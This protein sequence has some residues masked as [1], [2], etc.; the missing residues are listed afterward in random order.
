MFILFFSLSNR[1]THLYEREGDGK[2][3]ILWG[4]PKHP[5]NLKD[6]SQ[7]PGTGSHG[8]YP[9]LISRLSTN[10]LSSDLSSIQKPKKAIYEPTYFKNFQILIKMSSSVM[11]KIRVMVYKS[12]IFGQTRV[13]ICILLKF[14]A[15]VKNAWTDTAIS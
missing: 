6:L 11:I 14:V 7:V 5:C 3:N 12:C 10:C 9:Y 13:C 1:T 4:W 8:N 2:Q 15:F